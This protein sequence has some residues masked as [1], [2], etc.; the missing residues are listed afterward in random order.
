MLGEYLFIVVDSLLTSLIAQIKPTIRLGGLRGC[1]LCR[2]WCGRL[3]G[4][5]ARRHRILFG[6]VVVFGVA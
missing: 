3:V 2:W 6:G 5:V 4:H 1:R